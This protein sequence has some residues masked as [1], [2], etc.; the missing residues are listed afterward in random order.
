MSYLC[1]SP[2]EYQALCLLADQLPRGMGLHALQHFLVAYLPPN[3]LELA[4]RIGRLDQRHMRLLA[5]HLRKRGQA[6]GV[7]D[8]RGAFSDEELEAVAGACDSSR[9]PVRFLQYYRFLLVEKLSGT[10]SA[11]ARKLARLSERQ[12]ARLYEQLKGRRNGSA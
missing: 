1:F 12:F 3:Q 8:G 2:D 4:R 6:G 7:E 9:H 11:L 10:H 5:Q